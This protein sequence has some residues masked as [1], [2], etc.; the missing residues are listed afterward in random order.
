[1]T[2]PGPA[3][4]AQRIS[5][6]QIDVDLWQCVVAG[7]DGPVILAEGPMRSYDWLVAMLAMAAAAAKARIGPVAPEEMTARVASVLQ[8]AGIDTAGATI[9]EPPTEAATDL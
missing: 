8:Q 7:N 5:V 6:N 2:P 3:L 1:M 4:V 9:T